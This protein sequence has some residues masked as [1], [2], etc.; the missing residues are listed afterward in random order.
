MI[1]YPYKGTMRSYDGSLFDVQ[2]V[3]INDPTARTLQFA[4][5]FVSGRNDPV[6]N[7]DTGVI[8]EIPDQKAPRSDFPNPGSGCAGCYAGIEGWWTGGW[9]SGTPG[10]TIGPDG[11]ATECSGTSGAPFDFG[12]DFGFDS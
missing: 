1:P 3:I 11:F 5:P 4:Q 12:F 2:W 7:F 9:P 10:V 6:G 8:G